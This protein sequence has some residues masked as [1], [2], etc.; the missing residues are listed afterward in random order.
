MKI[1]IWQLISLRAWNMKKHCFLWSTSKQTNK[2]NNSN[3]SHNFI[4]HIILLTT[5]ILVWERITENHEFQEA[6]LWGP[7]SWRLT[8]K[9]SDIWCVCVCVFVCGWNACVR[10]WTSLGRL[11][12]TTGVI[13]E[14]LSLYFYFVKQSFLL[15]LEF[16]NTTRMSGQWAPRGSLVIVS[17]TLELQADAAT[18]GFSFFFF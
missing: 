11:E 9:H 6:D 18:S 3:K 7:L 15:K 2:Q 16:T 12:S 8:I 4:N 1:L 14:L 5:W 10:T 17:S 13:L